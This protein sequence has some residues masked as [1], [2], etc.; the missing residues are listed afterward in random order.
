MFSLIFDLILFVSLFR[1][2]GKRFD[3]A[4]GAR[5]CLVT[6][7]CMIAFM[8]AILLPAELLGLIKL[9]QV[10]VQERLGKSQSTL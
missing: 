4:Y 8:V 2:T 6:G 1:S 7:L 10:I 9:T 3:V 5:G